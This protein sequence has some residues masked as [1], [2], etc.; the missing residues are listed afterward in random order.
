MPKVYVAVSVAAPFVL[1]TQVASPFVGAVELSM[2]TSFGSELVHVARASIS[3]A[4][5][6]H[7]GGAVGP[8][9]AINCTIFPGT[10]AVESAVALCGLTDIV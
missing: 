5:T 2:I 9:V 10:G 8:T 7:P 3:H 6:A 1:P 4:G